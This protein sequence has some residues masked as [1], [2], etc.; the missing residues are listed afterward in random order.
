MLEIKEHHIVDL[1]H[2]L[3]YLEMKT[4]LVS[5]PK[6]ICVLQDTETRALWPSSVLFPKGRGWD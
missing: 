6:V 4:S 3:I 2:V 5:I 1:M